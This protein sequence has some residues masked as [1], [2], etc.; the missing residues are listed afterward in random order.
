MPI[1]DN[2]KLI[3]VH[4][5]KCGGSSINHMLGISDIFDMNRLKGWIYEQ[6][7]KGDKKVMYGNTC[8]K[9]YYYELDHAL[10]SHI[11]QYHQEKCKTYFKFAIVRNPY[12]R[13]LSEFF[14]NN[15]RFIEKKGEKP[16]DFSNYLEELKSRWDEINKLDHFKYSHFYPQFYFTNTLDSNNP[17][18]AMDYICKLEEIT[19]LCSILKKKTGHN[20]HLEEHNV[21]K[22]KINKNEY[23][24]ENNKNIIYDLYKKDF[25]Q[26]NYNK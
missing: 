17:G 2:Y 7:K 22:K 11:N 14:Y 19:E 4:I 26:F 13:L 21:N 23:L 8:R 15:S 5:P 1:F 24:T 20:F 16:S 18:C 6:V 3:F 10:Y 12:D 9:G 25:K